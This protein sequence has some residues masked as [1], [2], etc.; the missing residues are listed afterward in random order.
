[1]V[2]RGRS[3][4][5]KVAGAWRPMRLWGRDGSEGVECHV[6]LGQVAPLT[7]QHCRAGLRRALDLLRGAGR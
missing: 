6:C 5:R 3:A 7:L 2:R 4:A 1:M